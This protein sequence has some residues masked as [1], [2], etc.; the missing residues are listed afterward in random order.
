MALKPEVKTAWIEALRSGDYKQGRG[1]L[2]N[3]KDQMC[4]LGV[5]YD[6]GVDGDWSLDKGAADN[7]E[8]V[9]GIR[10]RM[11]SFYGDGF[12]YEV[13]ASELPQ[14]VLNKVGLEE[15]QQDQLIQLNDAEK[16]SFKYIARY[17]EKN[18]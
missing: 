8:D 18:L 13:N 9:W 14:T 16:R 2:C 3:A 7:G 12:F 10:E 5:L 17:I 4:C 15:Y 1:L 11:H 6:V